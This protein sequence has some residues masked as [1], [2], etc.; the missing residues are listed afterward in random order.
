M[1]G[2]TVTFLTSPVGKSPVVPFTYG[3]WIG[4]PFT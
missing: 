3:S 4:T 2:G 1:F